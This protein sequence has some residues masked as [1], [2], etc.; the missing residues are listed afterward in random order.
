LRQFL[1]DRNTVRYAD[2]IGV[3][4]LNAGPF[5]T[6]VEQRV[7]ARGLAFV[8]DFLRSFTLSLRRPNSPA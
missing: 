8:V 2:K 1:T 4:E 7:D 6:I 5:V 3:F